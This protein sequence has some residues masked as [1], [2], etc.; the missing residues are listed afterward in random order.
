MDERSGELR[1]PLF[2]LPNVVHFP[3]TYLKLHVFEPRYRRL[4]HDLMERT[5]DERAIG[6]VLLKPGWQRDYGGRPEIFSAGTA[7]FLREV[8]MLPDGR[9]NIVL[10]GDFRFEIR[11][12]ID[13]R[14]YREALVEP[15][16]E[17]SLDE[18][19]SGVRA[20]R[21][22]LVELSERLAEE[23]VETFPVKPGELTELAQQGSFE[24]L[25]NRL[26]ADL[27][28]P[29]L[30]KLELLSEPLPSRATGLL[31]ILQSR[32]KVL[33]LLRPYRHLA[34]RAEHN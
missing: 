34:G 14:A 31:S 9:S 11:R 25:V 12:E 28:V 13:E 2:P 1:L 30:R 29:A 24:E 19:D 22:V 10:E 8:E 23:L 3:R 33:D 7:G 20:V 15:V 21:Q 32:K 16:A 27:D 5:E 18:S 26:A 4:V 6:M 17:P